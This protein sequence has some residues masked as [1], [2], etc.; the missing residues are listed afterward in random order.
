MIQLGFQSI[1]QPIETRQSLPCRTSQAMQADHASRSY[2]FPS[3]PVYCSV[4]LCAEFV[5]NLSLGLIFQ[6]AGAPQG[7]SRVVEGSQQ[8][9]YS[10]VASSVSQ[11]TSCKEHYCVH[12]VQT[13]L[14]Q[15]ALFLILV[16]IENLVFIG[17]TER[18]A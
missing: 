17:V 11:T 13:Y 12:K 14:L 8:E 16:S 9:L 1:S 7:T 18:K 3:P 15:R 10:K 5:K 6:F 2:L 4:H